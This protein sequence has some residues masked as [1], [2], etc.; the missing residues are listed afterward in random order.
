MVETHCNASVQEKYFKMQEKNKIIKLE[1]IEKFEIKENEEVYALLDLKDL[2]PKEISV[3]NGG[4]LNLIVFLDKDF[5]ENLNTNMEINLRSDCKINITQVFLGSKIFNLN[6]Q[7][8]Y[9]GNNSICDLKALYIAN[10]KQKYNLQITNKFIGQNN[11]GYTLIKGIVKDEAN[12][13]VD[14]VIEIDKTGR[15]TDAKLQEHA[16]NLSHKATVRNLPILKIDTN[17]VKASHAASV[18][19]VNPEDLFYLMSRG[20]DMKSAENLLVN[21]FVESIFVGGDELFVEEFERM[22]G[23]IEGKL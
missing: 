8:N 22:K 13:N 23:E 10:E 16:L 3:K 6:F 17:D 11:R 14:G 1:N 12:V 20:I 4:I 21:A 2:I 5:D 7:I 18:T 9:K 15:N 19:R